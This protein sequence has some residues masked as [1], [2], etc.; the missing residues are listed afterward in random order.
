MHSFLKEL[1]MPV[2]AVP[3][4]GYNQ[5]AIFNASNPVQEKPTKHIDIRFHYIH[6]KVSDGEVTLHFVTTDQNPA[7]MFTKNLAR[8]NFLRCRSQLG[9]TFN[10]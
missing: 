5:G 9:I 10:K 2:D 1:R 7:D 8:D 3:L 6:K 4:C